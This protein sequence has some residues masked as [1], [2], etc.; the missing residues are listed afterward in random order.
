MTT[1]GVRLTCEHRGALSLISLLLARAGCAALIALTGWVQ[2]ARYC[3][4]KLILL[5][6]RMNFG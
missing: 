3:C 1:A 2:L 5:V 6:Q 4:V